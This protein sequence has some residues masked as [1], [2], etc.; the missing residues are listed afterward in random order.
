MDSQT[1]YICGATIYTPS[2]QIFNGA[3][4]VSDG[5]IASIGKSDEVDIP[6]D[7]RFVDATGMILAPG[8]IDLQFN[9]GFGLDFTSDPTTIWDVAADLPRYG[10]T[11]FLPTVITSPLETVA[12]AQK[13]MMERK[14]DRERGSIPLGLHLEGPFLNPQK[15]GAHNP[16]HLRT[17]D[18]DL[19]AEWSPGSGVRLVTLAPELPGALEMI[20]ALVD[21]GVVVSAGHSAARY[22]EAKAGLEAGIRYGTHLFNAMPGLYHRNPGLVGALL[23][24]ARPAVGIIPDGIHLHP[25]IVKTVWETKT[26]K[27]LTL[28]T[29]AM[30]ALGMR[31]GRFQIADRQVFVTDTDARLADGTLAGS[32]LSMDAALRNLIKFTDCTLQQA[33]PTVTTTPATV[34]GI[35][36]RKGKI[37]AGYDADLVLLTP[38]LEVA[39]T[40]VEGGIVYQQEEYSL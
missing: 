18:L 26:L 32:I 5:N 38:N 13:V 2:A 35:V 22:D 4:L 28:V 21:R 3:L 8:F 10:V 7:A 25:A 40:I 15:K 37:A 19:V 11:T 17:P 24:D 1:L 30:A 39:A 31:P 33:L 12:E 9:G 14:N 34:L 36:D 20:T 27:G 6:E 23:S 29:D 16:E